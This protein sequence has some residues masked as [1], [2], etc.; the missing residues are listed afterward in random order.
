MPEVDY[1]RTDVARRY[2]QG[3]ELPDD[4][5]DRWGAAVRPYLPSRPGLR[6]LD[7]GAGTGIFARAWPSWTSCGV[8]AVE[9]AA[10]MRAELAHLG[11]GGAVQAAAGRAEQIPLRSGS[12]DV[13]WLSTVVHHLRDLAAGAAEV[14]RVLAA[15]GVVFVRGLFADLGRIPGLDLVPGS[16]RAVAAFPTV[17]TVESGFAAAGLPLRAAEE[18]VDRGAATVGQ[19]SEWIRTMRHADTLLLRFTDD[20]LEAGLEAM[21]TLDPGSLLEPATLGLLVLVAA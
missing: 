1:Q 18:V 8:V 16:A 15:D 3:R 11:T 6:V 14:R 12:V 2:S 5:L 17:A 13:A 20:E 9:P 7:L 19:T 10:G 4:V 21:G